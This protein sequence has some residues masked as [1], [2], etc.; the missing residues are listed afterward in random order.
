MGLLYQEHYTSVAPT[1][2]TT[3]FLE[4]KLIF[5][6][7]QQGVTYA[8]ILHINAIQEIVTSDELR[9]FFIKLAEEELSLVDK[10]RKY[11]KLKGWLYVTPKFTIGNT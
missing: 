4:D 9:D 7:I 2:E 5:N 8:S 10:M 11:G 6:I 3:E 1:P